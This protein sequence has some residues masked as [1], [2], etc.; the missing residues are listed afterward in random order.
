MKSK[1]KYFQFCVLSVFLLILLSTCSYLSISNKDSYEEDTEIKHKITKR[2]DNNTCI[3]MGRILSQDKTQKTMAVIAYP[4]DQIKGKNT[5]QFEHII[6]TKAGTYMMYLPKGAYRIYLAI[7]FNE[8]DLFEHTE[9]SGSYDSFK[10]VTLKRG[11]V[12]TGI[13]IRSKSTPIKNTGIPPQFKIEYNYYSSEYSWRNGQTVKF[14]DA[15]FSAN[16]A[17]VGLWAPSTFMSSLG[18]NIFFLEKYDPQKIPI[19][20]VHGSKGNPNDWAYFLIRMDRKRFQPWFFYYPSGMRLPLISRI[21]HE[22]LSDLHK[23]YQFS[24]MCITAHSMGG[25]VTRALLTSYDQEKYDNL[26]KLYVTLATPW[27]GFESADTAVETSPVKLPNWIDMASRSMFIKKQLRKTLPPQIPYHLFYGKYDVVS[28]GRA[29]DER[30]FK[31]AAGR[32]AFDVN[33]DSILSDKK[34][35]IKYND[36]LTGVF[37]PI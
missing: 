30:I 9:I 21:L 14:Y 1:R 19:L 28:G 13:D 18:A 24:Q 17:H 36:I 2:P 16:N 25:L 35:F 37:F 11:D 3:I 15:I 23:T 26:V 20:F 34:V 7:D 29:L 31:G 8:D 32:H 10:T 4:I 27:S 33:H 5:V 6:L 12:K 22:K